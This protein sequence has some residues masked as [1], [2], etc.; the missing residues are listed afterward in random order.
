MNSL[1]GPMDTAPPRGPL[2]HDE[3]TATELTE[4]DL[5]RIESAV[6]TQLRDCRLE[7][8]H[9]RYGARPLWLY[10]THPET[11]SWA[12]V[13]FRDDGLTTLVWQGGPRRLWDEAE[14][15][16]HHP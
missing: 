6:C 9:K 16:M 2:S 14:N 10:G 13:L 8:G 15:V 5:P 1:P 4:A 7:L 3:M 11:H 12:C